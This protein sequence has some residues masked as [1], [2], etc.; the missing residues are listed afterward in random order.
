M[1]DPQRIINTVQRAAA[2]FSIAIAFLP[3]AVPQEKE[4]LKQ[5]ALKI[6]SQSVSPTTSIVER[7]LHEQ[8]GLALNDETAG[9]VIRF[10]GSLYFD[11]QTRLPD[12]QMA[13]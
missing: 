13:R 8:R 9:A 4:R 2:L 3:N 10:H 6:W 7:Y 11:R 12:C 5:L 1:P